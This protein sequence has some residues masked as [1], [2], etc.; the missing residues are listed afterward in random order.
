[1]SVSEHAPMC[2]KINLSLEPFSDHPGITDDEGSD[3]AEAGSD[4]AEASES[5]GGGSA[6]G[7]GRPHQQE[8]P[9]RSQLQMSPEW[10]HNWEE[11]LTKH[12]K[13]DT[14][15]HTKDLHALLVELKG[16]VWEASTHKDGCHVVQ[17]AMTHC[18]TK[19]WPVLL[20]ELHGKV[21]EAVEHPQA[22]FVLQTII[23]AANRHLCRF[24]IDECLDKAVDL[25]KH[26]YGCRIL[27]RISEHCLGE[28]NAM[29]LIQRVLE[30][31]QVVASL[32]CHNFGHHVV[33][34]IME[35]GSPEHRKIIADVLST[36]LI[37]MAQSRH[38]SYII[39]AAFDFCEEGD[40]KKLR[41]MLLQ[42]RCIIDLAKH[43][44]GGFVVKKLAGK[45]EEEDED[46]QD[47]DGDDG[48]EE[49]FRKETQREVQRLLK[50]HETE[51]RDEKNG[52][53]VWEDVFTAKDEDR[54]EQKDENKGTS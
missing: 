11:K 31:P 10:K 7:T 3:I 45:E 12:E 47:D 33:Q 5:S 49:A 9:P 50:E 30:D 44:F 8:T 34:Q 40:K 36:D 18:K 21:W 2:I 28:D 41:D 29:L 13:K 4:I 35:K 20:E 53:K 52:K 32:C 43:Q 17:L 6:I 25:A 39:E 24:I 46:E 22:N 15:D 54:M 26:R 42:G 16:N 19:D 27:C 51:L 23:E 1:M 37:K 14:D 48:G 38:A